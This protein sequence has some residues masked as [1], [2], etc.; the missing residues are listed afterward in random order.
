MKDTDPS[1]SLAWPDRFLCVF[2]PTQKEK[3]VWSCEYIQQS[4]NLNEH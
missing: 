2:I 1:I 3:V 4:Q